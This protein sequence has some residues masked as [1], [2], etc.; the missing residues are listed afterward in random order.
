MTP[1][2]DLIS[3]TL[4]LDLQQMQVASLRRANLL[5]VADYA[6]W[7]IYE[8]DMRRQFRLWLRAEVVGEG[9]RSRGVRVMIK[10]D[11][12]MTASLV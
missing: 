2:P 6:S 11:V 9:V 8:R 1:L 10:P 12:I 3:A 7:L 5:S 4:D